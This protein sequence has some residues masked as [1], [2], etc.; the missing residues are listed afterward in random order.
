MDGRT[1]KVEKANSQGRANNQ[2]RAPRTRTYNDDHKLI[3]SSER[4]CRPVTS[5]TVLEHHDRGSHQRVL[6]F[7]R[8]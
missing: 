8:A 7:W 3:V 6:H 4:C 1:V 5:R 2:E